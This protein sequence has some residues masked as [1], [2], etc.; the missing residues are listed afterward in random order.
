MTLYSTNF[1]SANR[2]LFF[3]EGSYYV[4]FR[5]QFISII[6]QLTREAS[7]GAK[8]RSFML[9]KVT[10]TSEP[11]TDSDEKCFILGGEEG[12]VVCFGSSRRA[13]SNAFYW[14][15]GDQTNHQDKSRNTTL[16]FN[17][18]I[19]LTQ[20]VRDSETFFV[21][22]DLGMYLYFLLYGFLWWCWTSSCG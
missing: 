10:F 14:S 2:F 12:I 15:A 13:Q 18:Q 8:C 11:S 21:V 7:I 17:L 9:E 19:S 6:M 5:N 16:C 1:I 4:M 20:N 3:V 22:G